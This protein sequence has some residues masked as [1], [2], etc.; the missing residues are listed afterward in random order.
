MIYYFL[1]VTKNESNLRNTVSWVNMLL[2]HRLF[3]FNV[4]LWASL[5]KRYVLLTLKSIRNVFVQ[6]RVK[7][8][9]LLSV[10]YAYF[11]FFLSIFRTHLSSIS[12]SRFKPLPFHPH[13]SL[14][15]QIFLVVSPL[16][17]PHCYH[18]IQI[19]KLQWH[20]I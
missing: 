12:P 1:T 8:V 11:F 19:F 5:P 15:L 13:L 20:K 3:F 9:P 18:V 16:L 4:F 10:S 14:C 6:L 7:S 2:L 17:F